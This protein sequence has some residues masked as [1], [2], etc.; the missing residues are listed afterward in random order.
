[1]WATFIGSTFSHRPLPGVR[2]S[3]MPDGTDTPAPDSTTALFDASRSSAA[4]ATSSRLVRTEGAY[5]Q[6]KRGDGAAFNTYIGPPGRGTAGA[7]APSRGAA[8]GYRAASRSE[9]H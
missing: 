1:M 3:G 7:T 6:E 4:R 2:K 5:P 8:E 9:E